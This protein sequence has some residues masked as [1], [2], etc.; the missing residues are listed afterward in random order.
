MSCEGGGVI[1]GYVVEIDVVGASEEAE[2][3][4][5]VSWEE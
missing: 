5:A 1:A 3:L 4:S 2:S